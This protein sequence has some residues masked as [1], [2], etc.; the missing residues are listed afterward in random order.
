MQHDPQILAPRIR[1]HDKLQIRRRL[2]VVE[3]VAASSVGD[4]AAKA[5]LGPG[6]PEWTKSL[7]SYLSSGPP[8]FLTIPRNE[9]MVPNISFASSWA[10]R[11]PCRGGATLPFERSALEA[12]TGRGD[13]QR[14][15]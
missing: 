8:S 1:Q 15:E 3:L 10:E 2:I 6:S 14:R 7:V 11:A 9:K 5:L 4:E 12:E 13:T